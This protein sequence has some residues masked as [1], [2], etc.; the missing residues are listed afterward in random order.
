MFLRFTGMRTY[1]RIDCTGEFPGVRGCASTR[2]LT[3]RQ[4]RRRGR[5]IS[6]NVMICSNYDLSD[7]P[8]LY[9]RR[10]NG[11]GKALKQE[12]SRTKAPIYARVYRGTSF[13]SCLPKSSGGRLGRGAVTS[14][15]L[16]SGAC[17]DPPLRRCCTVCCLP[18]ASWSK[19]VVDTKA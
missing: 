4:M 14:A 15:C 6:G 2:E 18:E 7:F 3:T 19:V 17:L 13:W 1:R 8:C 5:S 16:I 10:E 12:S 9:S 11:A